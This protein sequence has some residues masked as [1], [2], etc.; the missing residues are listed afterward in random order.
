MELSSVFPFVF[1][2]NSAEVISL[3][4]AKLPSLKT[5]LISTIL[6]RVTPYRIDVVPDE[7]LPTIPPI[8]QRFE[9]EVLG[10]KNNLCGFKNKF[11]SSRITPGCT[12]IVLLIASKATIFVKC[13]E[14]STI[15]PLPTV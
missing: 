5:A 4:T 9:V 2:I 15:I 10:P 14:T 7:L 11:S 6:S 3:N 1:S 13:L 8:I 12:V